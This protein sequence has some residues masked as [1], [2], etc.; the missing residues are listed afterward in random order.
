MQTQYNFTH[1]TIFVICQGFFQIIPARRI[2]YEYTL[3]YHSFYYFADEKSC[4]NVIHHNK[5][6]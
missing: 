5:L 4:I 2:N 6:F 3:Y 1:L